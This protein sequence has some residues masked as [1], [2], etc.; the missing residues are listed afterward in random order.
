MAVI[1]PHNGVP[2][3]I[4]HCLQ[5]AARVMQ[6]MGMMMMRVRDTSTAVVA[7]PPVVRRGTVTVV[8]RIHSPTV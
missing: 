6:R 1:A 4:V 5:A 3:T 8:E 7:M 2:A